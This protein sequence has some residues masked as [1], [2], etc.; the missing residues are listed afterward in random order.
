M[1]GG[2]AAQEAGLAGVN[3]H[4]AWLLLLLGVITCGTG[5]YFMVVRPAILPEDVRFTKLVP[6][7]MPTEA[8]EWLQIVFRTWGAFVFGFGVLLTALASFIM[9]TRPGFLRWGVPIALIV[10]FGRFLAS[11]VIL[12]SDYLWFI[13]ALFALSVLT[14]IGFAL[15]APHKPKQRDHQ[16]ERYPGSS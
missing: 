16:S 10:P 12:R 1:K 13:A 6:Q 4:A 7:E 5:I 14:A 3:R 11:N 15:P 2:L 9:K 8:L